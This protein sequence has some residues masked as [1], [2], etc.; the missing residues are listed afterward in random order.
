MTFFTDYTNLALIAI[1]L[2]SGG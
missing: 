1:L 2:V